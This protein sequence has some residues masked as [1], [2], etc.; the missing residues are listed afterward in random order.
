MLGTHWLWGVPCALAALGIA[1][2]FGD[3][4]V[5]F[6]AYKA[7]S[8]GQEWF[9][10]TASRVAIP[11]LELGSLLGVLAASLIYARHPWRALRNAS[12]V[13]WASAVL[14][15]VVYV[16]DHPGWFIGLP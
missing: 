11:F 2:L 8:G 1:Y 12:F 16:I 10:D 3:S 15:V 5:T 9:V 13:L 6:D 7:S 4:L 14:N